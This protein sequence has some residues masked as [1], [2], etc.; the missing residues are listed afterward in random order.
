M[1]QNAVGS[2]AG[3]GADAE[4]RDGPTETGQAIE[5]PILVQY[6]HVL[7]RWK[8]AVIGVVV[9]ALAAGLII[10]LLTTPKYTATSRIEINRAQQNV[11]KVDGL[12]AQQ[13]TRDD[14]FYQTQ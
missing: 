14:E 4:V 2:S 7:L 11:T 12:E 3:Y 5:A 8:W 13:D 9:A 1:E 10:T 6:W